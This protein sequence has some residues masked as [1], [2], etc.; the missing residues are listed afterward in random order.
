MAVEDAAAVGQAISASL[1]DNTSQVDW[2]SAVRKYH[3]SRSAQFAKG[4]DLTLL[5]NLSILSLSNVRA[6]R[7]LVIQVLSDLAMIVSTSS[8]ERTRNFFLKALPQQ[9]KGSAFDAV[10]KL[11]VKP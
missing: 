2:A 4:S 6:R 5:L 3:E 1:S 8:W 10:L 11:L 7:T 9:W